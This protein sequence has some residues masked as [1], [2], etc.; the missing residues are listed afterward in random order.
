MVFVPEDIETFNGWSEGRLQLI[1]GL[2]E[3][4]GVKDIFNKHLQK[5]TGRPSD[6]PPG[7]EAEVMIAGICIDEG[8][9][10]LYAMQDYYEYKDLTG[11]FHHPMK[12]SQLNDDRFGDFL[13]DFYNAGPR[14]I[15]MEISAR[16]FAEYGIAVRNINYDTTSHVMWGEY[17]NT[18]NSLGPEGDISHISI[19]FGHSKN[20]RGDKKQ[21]KIGLGTTNGVITDAKL[22]SGNMDDKTYNKENLEDVDQLLTQMKVNRREFYYIADAALFTAENIKKANQ[23]DIM[24]ITRMPDHI[25]VAKECIATPLPEHAQTLILENAQGKKLA[26]R[27]IEKQVEYEGNPC[28]IA[29]IHSAALEPIKRKTSL[30][31]VEKEKKKLDQEKKKYDKRL[32]TCST[33]AEKEAALFEKKVTSKLKYHQVTFTIIEKTKNRPGRPSKDKTQ[34]SGIIEYQIQMNV[35]VDES[36]IEENI[37]K[38]CTFILC[39]NDLSITGENLLR[40]YKTQSDVEKRFKVLKSP[41][42]MNSL[43]LKTPQ[44]VEAL[45]YLLLISLMML[46]VAE[47]VVRDE[48]KKRGEVVYGI[49]KRKVKEPTLTTILKIMDRMR[50][51]TFLSDGKIQRKIR[52]TDESCQKI[53][54]FLRLPASCFEWNGDG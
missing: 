51:T 17:E 21:I 18:G 49:E 39:S 19:D 15:F 16:A 29:V 31:N 5:K 12:L 53:I 3:K 22:L 27:F 10:P 38:E 44:R 28:K 7:I 23:Y 20:K 42:F 52:N 2:C 30:R 26:Y 6:I 54:Q 43:F 40:E 47:R 45:V 35:S 34:D 41:Q 25:K 32:F 48:L 50:V 36:R 1:V 9:R 11:I 14:R 4:M 33:D 37:R 24:Y 46:T 8:Y 13:D